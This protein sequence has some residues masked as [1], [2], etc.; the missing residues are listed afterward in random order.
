MIREE[1]ISISAPGLSPMRT[2]TD[3]GQGNGWRRAREMR[4]GSTVSLAGNPITLG[5]PS[6][7]LRAPPSSSLLLGFIRTLP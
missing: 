3:R 5:W 6:S 2:D 4:M 7:I 1:L